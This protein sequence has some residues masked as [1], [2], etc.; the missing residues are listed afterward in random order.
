MRSA[1]LDRRIRK[2]AAV[3]VRDARAALSLKEGLRGKG[4]DLGTVTS[5][6]EKGLAANDMTTVRRQL[7]VLDALVDELVKR[8]PQV[9]DARVHRV[10]RHAR[11]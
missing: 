5:E 11:S 4:G 7:P 1:S 2:E 6:V 10:D 9:D 3:L 8:P